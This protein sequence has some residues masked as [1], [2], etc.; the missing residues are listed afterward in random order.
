MCHIRWFTSETIMK[1]LKRF[2]LLWNIKGCNIPDLYWNMF[3]YRMLFRI[4][5]SNK[6]IHKCS[7]LL[8]SI[9]RIWP[10]NQ[11]MWV[12]IKI[13]MV[14]G[15]RLR[16]GIKITLQY[17][18]WIERMIIIWMKIHYCFD[19]IVSIVPFIYHF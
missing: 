18:P 15:K 1:C 12:W 5:I 17:K 13:N 6:K 10:D 14:T 19:N 9:I 4:C 3:G 11:V 16:C 7:L 2:E 8:Q